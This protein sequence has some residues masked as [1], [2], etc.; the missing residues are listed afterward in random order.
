MTWS[1]HISYLVPFCCYYYHYYCQ[2]YYYLTSLFRIHSS[3]TLYRWTRLPL[4]LQLLLLLDTASWSPRP[5]HLCLPLLVPA[6]CKDTLPPHGTRARSSLARIP[7]RGDPLNRCH[8]P[9]PDPLA[10]PP[11][12]R[13]GTRSGT[14]GFCGFSC[15][16]LPPRRRGQTANPRAPALSGAACSCGTAT[17][18]RGSRS[19][20]STASYRRSRTAWEP[21]A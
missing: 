13:R 6:F 17:P 11:P 5:L 18:G 3:H 9:P 14:V 4:V 10:L 21:R 20:G 15:V 7:P 12:L 2:H 8:C 16:G 1:I 19:P